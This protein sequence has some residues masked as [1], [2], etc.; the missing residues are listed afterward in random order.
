[1]VDAKYTSRITPRHQDGVRKYN[2]IRSTNDDRP[3]V[4]QVWLAHPGDIRIAP[5]DE[6][7]EWTELGPNR[8]QNE[9]INGT[10]GII[11][12][13]SPATEAGDSAVNETMLD[14]AKG[15]LVYLGIVGTQD[16]REHALAS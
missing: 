3:V 11:P 12:P 9:I 5:W 6:A 8:P 14:F 16:G 4:K 2:E 1:V 10:L 7:V 15:I 13:S